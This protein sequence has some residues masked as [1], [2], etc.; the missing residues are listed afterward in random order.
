MF[1]HLKRDRN[2]NEDVKNKEG[3]IIMVDKM[4]EVSLRQAST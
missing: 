3:I 1:R 4:R 2:K